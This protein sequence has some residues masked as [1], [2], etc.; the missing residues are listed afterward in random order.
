MSIDELDRY[1]GCLLGLAAGDA[2]GTTLEFRT[3]GSFEPIDDMVGGGPF[4]LEP[5]MWTDDT[6]MALC[7]AV[8]LLESKGF[9][10]EDQMR[11]Y[12]RWYQE[13]YMSSTGACFDIGN[14]VREALDNFIETGQAYSRSTHAYSAGNGSL[15]RLAPVPMFFAQYPEDAIAFSANSSRTTHGAPEAID[16][17]RYFG[18]LL[19]GALN[20]EDKGTLLRDHYCPTPGYWERH[21]LADKIAEAAA[22]SFK[23]K[24]PPEV[25]GTGYVVESLE[26]ALWAFH[27]SRGFREGAL[28]AANLGDDADTTAA[29]YGQI[30]GA[31]YGVESIPYEWL[32]KLAKLTQI[33]KLANNLLWQ[34]WGWFLSLKEPQ[35]Q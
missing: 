17:C 2:L 12:V 3:P 8:S 21:P 4:G 20:G 25:R 9:D 26:A 7:L 1:R 6:S 29:I 15:M 11:R 5:G 30:A 31:H 28:M 19:V 10:P 35:R 14:T 18:G 24:G 34:H 16:A 23:R 33:T 32:S 13:G 22:G 27:N